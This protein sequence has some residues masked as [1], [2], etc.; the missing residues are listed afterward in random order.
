MHN[1]LSTDTEGLLTKVQATGVEGGRPSP[2][3]GRRTFVGIVQADD[4]CRRWWLGV[5]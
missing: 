4:T 2:S 1:G 3:R 5:L